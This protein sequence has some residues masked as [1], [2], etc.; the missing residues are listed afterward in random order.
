MLSAAVIC[1]ALNIYHEARGEPIEGQR[2]VASV[3]L[4]RT[5][6]PRWPST[7]CG[8][9]YDPQQFSWTSHPRLSLNPKPSLSH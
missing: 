4:N 8:V 7:V 6:D 5:L 1:L 2:A 3:T 9:V